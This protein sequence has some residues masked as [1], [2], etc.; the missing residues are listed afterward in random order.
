MGRQEMTMPDGRTLTAVLREMIETGNV[1]GQTCRKIAVTL[2]VSSSAVWQAMRRIENSGIHP[3]VGEAPPK[4]PKPEKVAKGEP[5]L[6]YLELLE[7][8]ETTAEMTPGQRRKALS[9]IGAVGP[10]AAKVAA[11]RTLEELDRAAGVSNPMPGP[12]SED[13]AVERVAAVL[14]AAGS[15]V[16]KRAL[17]LL[18][19]Q[20][21]AKDAASQPATVVEPVAVEG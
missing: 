16:T 17:E 5:R 8:I 1:A 21:A 9:L 11:I 3:L 19:S 14:R 15:G 13:E 18:R 6:S 2:G 7:K 12:T 10:D 4:E 20:K